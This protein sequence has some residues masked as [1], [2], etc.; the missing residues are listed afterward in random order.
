M[1]LVRCDHC[2]AIAEAGDRPADLADGPV[3][4]DWLAVS[5]VNRTDPRDP[6]FTRHFCGWDCLS[7]YAAEVTDGWPEIEP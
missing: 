6:P 7:K 4:H 2:Q 3:A 1:K 5:D